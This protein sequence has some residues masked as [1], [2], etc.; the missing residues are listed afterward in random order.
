MLS[1][2]TKLP[3][4]LPPLLGLLVATIV[5]SASARESLG[6]VTP[7]PENSPSITC[8][9]RPDMD[10]I[11]T[12]ETQHIPQM[13]QLPDGTIII[14]LNW[15]D[16]EGESVEPHSADL[17]LTSMPVPEPSYPFLGACAGCVVLLHRRR[18]MPGDFRPARISLS[19]LP[20][21]RISSQCS[22]RAP[23]SRQPVG[24]HRLIARRSTGRASLRPLR[25][26]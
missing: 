10:G 17:V 12:E 16:N 7:L 15:N 4:P 19:G 23:L 6:D 26:A 21:E 13:H 2:L 11:A 8:L 9:A 14:T 3:L 18:S 5:F 24:S 22:A 25:I 1:A 20:L